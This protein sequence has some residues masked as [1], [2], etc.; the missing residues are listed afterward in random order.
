MEFIPAKPHLSSQ[1]Y[2]STNLKRSYN[3]VFGLGIAEVI[4]G[5]TSIALEISALVIHSKRSALDDDSQSLYPAF[6]AL[7]SP[8]IWCGALAVAT[9][10]LGIVLKKKPTRVMTII[11]IT[12]AVLTAVVMP[13][14]IVLS[15]L[16]GVASLLCCTELVILHAVIALFCFV[17]FV[18]SIIHASLCCAGT[19]NEENSTSIRIP[20]AYRYQSQPCLE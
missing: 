14:G 17:V 11:N 20:Y 16:A 1:K 6:L 10:I 8:G 9:G 19:I 3:G 13:V 2:Q 7:M 15:G 18:L 4:L 5:T 12:I